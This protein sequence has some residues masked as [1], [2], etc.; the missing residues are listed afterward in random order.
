M[1]RSPTRAAASPGACWAVACWAGADEQANNDTAAVRI[2]ALFMLRIILS[3]VF[4]LQSRPS[5]LGPTVRGRPLLRQLLAG[6]DLETP[7]PRVRGHTLH[8]HRVARPPIPFLHAGRS[9]QAN[10]FV[11]LVDHGDMGFDTG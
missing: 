6:A 3:P 4:R 5:V 10:T 11:S 2:S 8:F 7:E 1:T 9:E